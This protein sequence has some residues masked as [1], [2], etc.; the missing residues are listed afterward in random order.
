MWQRFIITHVSNYKP[1]GVVNI[2]VVIYLY[3]C[4]GLFRMLVHAEL[5]GICSHCF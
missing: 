4:S 3:I 5:F 1:L 2:N